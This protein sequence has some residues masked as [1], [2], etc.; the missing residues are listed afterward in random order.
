MLIASATVLGKKA[1]MP[2][3][4]IALVMLLSACAPQLPQR[5]VT[6]A[7]CALAYSDWAAANAR[8]LR[9]SLAAHG[10]DCSDVNSA[11]VYL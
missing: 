1:F 7:D 11:F 2:H 4:A 8:I 10:I 9:L 6:H 5:P 3:R